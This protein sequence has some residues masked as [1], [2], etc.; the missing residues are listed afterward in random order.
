MKKYKGGNHKNNKEE[1]YILALYNNL[2]EKRKGKFELYLEQLYEEQAR[3][4]I[5]M[6]AGSS[7]SSNI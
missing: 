4:S 1:Q 6:F 5:K 3:D 7:D 2:S